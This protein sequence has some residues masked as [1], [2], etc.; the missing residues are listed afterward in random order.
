[1]LKTHL[2]AMLCGALCVLGFYALY[3][4]VHYAIT[5]STSPWYAAMVVFGILL[6]GLNFFSAFVAW[7]AASPAPADRLH[8]A[9]TL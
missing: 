3:N 4:T 5:P 8:P 9:A 6:T 2:F 7:E 1:M